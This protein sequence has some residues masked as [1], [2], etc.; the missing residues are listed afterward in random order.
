MKKNNYK[1]GIFDSGI[2][3]LTT[4]KE[5]KKLLPNE[6]YIYYLDNKNIPYGDKSD[7]ELKIIAKNIINFFD[8]KK[9]K[10]IVIACNTMTTKC[11]E[12]LRKTYPD[13]I[14]IG[15]EPA[16]KV[17]CDKGYKNTLLMVTP[18]TAKSERLFKIINDNAKDDHKITIL[19][20]KGLA[21]TIET[22][23]KKRIRYLIYNLLYEYKIYN[24]D[25]VVL[26][27]THYCH[28]KKIISEIFP[29]AKL[30]DGNKGVSK[31]VKRKLEENN[32]LT[33]KKTKGNVVIYKSKD[34]K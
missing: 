15:T 23:D 16:I 7:D 14:F 18:A 3:G 27:C 26:G 22:K 32:L 21:D 25:S 12:Y 30:I 17:A 20:C 6:S 33:D 1:I 19:P 5:I 10:I 8:K 34:I 13:K 9:V 11:I 28:I 4:L 24:Y 31:E 29:N 2:G